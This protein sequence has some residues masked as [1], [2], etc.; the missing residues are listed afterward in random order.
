MPH[1]PIAESKVLFIALAVVASASVIL[2]PISM[3]AQ[4]GLAE[5]PSPLEVTE[6]PTQQEIVGNQSHTS[7]WMAALKLDT[8]NVSSKCVIAFSLDMK[9]KDSAGEL[10]ATY[11]SIRFFPKNGKL[12][13]LDPGQTY[14]KETPTILP[15]DQ[16]WNPSTTADITVDFVIF[17]DGSR[18]GPGNDAEQKG[19][20]LGRFDAYK[21]MQS[22][23]V[24]QN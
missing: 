1:R 16:S 13:C 20:L 3:P 2:L 23:K 15:T 11:V 21:Q 4:S 10:M 17:G 19:Y 5:G 18:W 12:N 6:T 8:R 7:R 24:Q 22:Q 9:F 14:T